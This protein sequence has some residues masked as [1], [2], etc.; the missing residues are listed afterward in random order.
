ML[1]THR[2]CAHPSVHRLLTPERYKSDVISPSFLRTGLNL[3]RQMA[4]TKMTL[5][6]LVDKSSDR[7]L[8]A[9]AGKEVVDFFLGLLNLPLSAVI[10]LVTEQDTMVGSIANL[11][12]TVHTLE[13][14]YYQSSHS[15]SAILKVAN[16][17]PPSVSSKG[18]LLIGTSAVGTEGYV[19]GVVT[20]T[21]T[22]DLTVTPMSS[23]SSITI[24]NRLHVK[25]L[26]ALQEQTVTL[27]LEQ[28]ES[29]ILFS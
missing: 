11:Y 21:I 6:L 20:Y 18:L 19:K 27:G 23:I 28:V 4:E 22:D 2:A 10:K 24:L 13:E 29:Q 15:K 3:P 5:K 25:N 17:H 9:E 16:S 1:N 12:Q 7:V 8:F 14:S 26:A